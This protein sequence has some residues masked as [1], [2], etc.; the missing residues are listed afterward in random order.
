MGL[1]RK[2]NRLH[3]YPFLDVLDTAIEDRRALFSCGPSPVLDKAVVFEETYGSVQWLASLEQCKPHYV[4]LWERHKR[5]EIELLFGHAPT[6]PDGFPLWGRKRIDGF[7]LIGASLAEFSSAARSTP[8]SA[9]LG[10]HTVLSKSM[11]DQGM[12][13]SCSAWLRDEFAAGKHGLK[14]GV[15]DQGKEVWVVL[16]SYCLLGDAP[17]RSEF[18]GKRLAFTILTLPPP[19]FI[20][21]LFLLR[22]WI[23]LTV[24]CFERPTVSLITVLVGSGLVFRYTTVSSLILCTMNQKVCSLFILSWSHYVFH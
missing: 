1:L 9:T 17:G 24:R 19:P 20:S 5:S 12:F 22:F 6:F 16:V 18:A 21:F 4:P 7:H 8:T 11:M 14:L 10:L 23:L 13:K 15:N 2:A 3:T